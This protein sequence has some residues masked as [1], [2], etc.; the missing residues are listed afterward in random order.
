MGLQGAEAGKV[1]SNGRSGVGGQA[2]GG[3]GDGEDREVGRS[4]PL[5]AS[6]PPPRPAYVQQER[7][8]CMLN[9]K[10][11]QN[12]SEATRGQHRCVGV[13]VSD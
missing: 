5:R 2:G 8:S 7:K 13:L 11:I 4:L 9:S 3:E 10:K 12:V 1:F 6:C